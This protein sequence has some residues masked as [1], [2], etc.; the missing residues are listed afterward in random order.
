MRTNRPYPEKGKDRGVIVDYWGVFDRLQAA[1]AEFSLEDVEMAVLDLQS[2]KD[3]FPTLVAEALALVAGMP[4]NDDE[5]EQMMWLLRRFM[6]DKAAAESFEQRFQ[7]AQSAYETLAPDPALLPHLDDY[8]RLVRVRALWRRGA[9]LDDRDSDFD[10]REYRPHT[11]A[12]VQE[13]VAVERLRRDLPIYRIDGQYL[14]RL[15]EAPGSP[16]EKAAE[17][18]A[19]IEYEIRARGGDKDP[20]ARSLAERLERIRRQKEEADADMLS[21]LEDLVG[22]WAAE[23]EAHEALGLSERAQGFLSLTRAQAPAGLGDDALV[24]LARRL[25]EAV[26][27]HATVSDWAERD[28]VRR[29]I[30]GEAMRTLLADEQTRSFVTPAFLDELMTVATAR[31]S[32]TA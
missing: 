9:R 8:R 4:G 27:K 30:R 5:Y 31:E 15:E 17:V 16:E 2:L 23:K 26:A 20:V 32:T 3:S 28:D 13:A 21:L 19:A 29:D 14:Q 10:I 7:A 18:E 22:D 24:D 12:L 6:G 1:F 11:H 25:D